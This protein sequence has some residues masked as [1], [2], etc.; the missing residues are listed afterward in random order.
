M[1]HVA[2]AKHEIR[3]LRRHSHGFVKPLRQTTLTQ[4]A[5]DLRA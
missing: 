3:S 1:T 5:G 2:L 4:P